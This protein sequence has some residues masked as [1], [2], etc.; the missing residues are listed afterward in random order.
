MFLKVYYF[1]H[2]LSGCDTVSSFSHVGKKTAWNIW[3]ASPATWPI[4]QQLS[5][6][7][8]QVT[9][10]D[11]VELERFVVLLYKRTSSLSKVNEARRQLFSNGNRPIDNIPPTEAA[12]LQHVKRAA[13][14]AG[15]VWGQSL[16]IRPTLPP[17]SEW[18]WIRAM[19]IGSHTGPI[20][21][22]Q[23]KFV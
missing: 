18:G 22:R 1:F 16:V 8:A 21:Q 19:E 3:R 15:H 14:Q 11:M 6:A 12:L 20:Y 17:P 4:F 5:C 2:A 13:Y 10:P 9:E 7:P 23:A